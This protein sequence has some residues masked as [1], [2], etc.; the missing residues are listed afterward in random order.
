MGKEEF[1]TYLKLEKKYSPLT[2]QSYDKDLTDLEDFLLTTEG[3]SEI[4]NADKKQLRNFLIHL[5][6]QKLSVRT[7]NQKISA[8]RSFFKYLLR[9]N[10]IEKNPASELQNL[11]SKKR[12]LI[13]Y[14]EE[15]IQF[16]E[17]HFNEIEE[18]TD[19]EFEKTRNLLI[20]EFFYRTGIRRIELIELEEAQIDLSEK[21]IR[22][23]GKRNKERQIPI[24]DELKAQII[25]YL[26]VKKQEIPSGEKYFFT[27]KK[28][29]ILK[30][31]FVYNLIN[32]YLSAVTT[33]Q[34]KSP[35]ML[36]H[37]F[38]THLLNN[39]AEL[40]SIKEILGHSS[41]AA[42]QVYTHSNIEDLKRV[43]NQAHPYG[44]KIEK[45]DEN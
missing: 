40:N 9:E 31:K 44:H 7:V 25:N 14:T 32:K 17:T 41:L 21:N 30:E 6:Q 36:R 16:F 33:K 5:T 24:T 18:D 15:E 12:V 1:L 35:H 8:V 20:F 10:E 22:V 43:F 29:K 39:G 27:D 42:T 2:V 37:T 23:I 26:K 4:H 3:F 19:S 45:K 13:P 28:G 38:A 11:K 34:K